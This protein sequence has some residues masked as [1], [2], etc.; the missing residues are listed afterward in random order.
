MFAIILVAAGLVF[1]LLY[2]SKRT[3]VKGVP[4]NEKPN[5]EPPERQRE[6]KSFMEQIREATAG[7]KPQKP[8]DDTD[9]FELQRE[10][11][12]ERS[13]GLDP[14]LDN[15]RARGNYLDD[16]RTKAINEII[17]QHARLSMEEAFRAEQLKVEAAKKAKEKEAD[18]A[19]ERARGNRV[20]AS[21]GR[22]YDRGQQ[23]SR[24][25]QHFEEQ[26]KKAREWN[27]QRE[28]SEQREATK[29]EQRQKTSQEALREHLAHVKV[30]P[31]DLSK[32]RDRDRGMER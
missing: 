5:T 20:V 27:E 13:S 21:R 6:R 28:Q 29:Q 25:A 32:D 3:G 16:E 1:A 10:R 14:E 8:D 18:K 30:P 4:A 7:I 31:R 12:R 22:G 9:P 19:K 11:S 2:V 23:G 17:E 24:L 15:T 26:F